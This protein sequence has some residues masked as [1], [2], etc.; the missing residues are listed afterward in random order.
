MNIALGAMNKVD[1]VLFLFELLLWSFQHWYNVAFHSAV[2]VE[3]SSRFLRA[4]RYAEN[5]R[6]IV[7]KRD[8]CQVLLALET[9]CYDYLMLAGS[10]LP[11]MFHFRSRNMT[12]KTATIDQVSAR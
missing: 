1:I 3:C 9:Q 11:R 8:Q 4:D 7:S 6:S 12:G 2:A 10:T 5:K